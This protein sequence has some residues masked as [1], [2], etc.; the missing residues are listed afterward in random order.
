MLNLKKLRQ[1]KGLSQQEIAKIFNMSFRG[2]QNIE[3]GYSQTSYENLIKFADFFNCS[4]DYLLGHQVN[5]TET[6]Q[7]LI[8]SIKTLDDDLCSLAEAYIEGLKT[9]QKH[10][11]M[12]RAR[13]QQS[14][15]E[16]DVDWEM[17]G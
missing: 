17:G 3:Y 8:A 13:H 6:Q 1:E 11:D 9:T 10:R 5:E 15:I 14:N 16:E 7:N 2:Y 12:I 4:I